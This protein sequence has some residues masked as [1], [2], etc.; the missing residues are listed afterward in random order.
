MKIYHNLKTAATQNFQS[1]QSIIL[2][3]RLYKGKQMKIALEEITSYKIS[4]GHLEGGEIAV[5]P[6]A[7]VIRTQ[8]AYD[9]KNILPEVGKIVA[10]KLNLAPSE[11]MNNY[12]ASWIL[13]GAPNNISAESK[14]L[15]SSMCNADDEYREKLL[16]A[17][18]KFIAWQNKSAM[19][20]SKK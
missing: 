6:A 17:Q 5:K 3:A 4:A 19:E 10:E 20:R 11:K 1:M 18:N 15:Q 8:S 9:W 13:D 2:L 16:T 14:D 12:I 7:K